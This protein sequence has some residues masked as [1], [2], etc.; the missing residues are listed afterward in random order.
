MLKVLKFGGTSVGT[1]DRIQNVANII[2]KIKDEGHDVIA[3]VSAMS[4]ETN[5]LI[6]YAEYYSKTPK[7]DEIDMLL[8]SG[9]RVTSALLSIALNEMGYKATSMSGRE[10]G[11][12]TDGAH[13]KAR[14]EHIDTT[15]MKK[16]IADGNII[17][18]AGFQGVV[19]DTLRVSTL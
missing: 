17:I 19:Q 2:K 5:K 8:S 16:A 10:A 4:G 12:V 13:T 15:G 18:V 7:L 9:E 6:E 1:L 3:V 11:I 14:I